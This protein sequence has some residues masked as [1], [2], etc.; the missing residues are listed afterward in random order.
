MGPWTRFVHQSL[1]GVTLICAPLNKVFQ[2]IISGY[3]YNCCIFYR[4]HSLHKPKILV[5]FQNINFQNINFISSNFF[6]YTHYGIIFICHSLDIKV[7][8]TL[9]SFLISNFKRFACFGIKR[10]TKVSWYNSN[11]YACIKIISIVSSGVR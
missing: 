11:I 6:N 7:Q 8:L 2:I 5:N 1:S 3:G 4:H 10:S 9:E